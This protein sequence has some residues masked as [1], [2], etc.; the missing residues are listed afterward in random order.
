MERMFSEI[1]TYI[2]VYIHNIQ[3]TFQMYIYIYIIKQ[4]CSHVK[5]IINDVAQ[6]LQ[7]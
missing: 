7:V 6:L 1:Y 3:Y 5:T 2:F 4:F